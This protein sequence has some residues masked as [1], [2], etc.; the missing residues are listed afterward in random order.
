MAFPI[1]KNIMTDTLLIHENKRIGNIVTADIDVI[2][3]STLIVGGI[4]NG[5]INVHK[6]AIVIV[7]GIVN[8]NIINA[9]T[10]KIFG[11]VNGN[12]I[13]N[14]GQFEIDKGAL[15]NP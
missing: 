3:S 8:G 11:I 5:Q 9:G 15:I 13:E 2:N 10:C 7:D 1:N 4:V 14:G 6:S 12:L